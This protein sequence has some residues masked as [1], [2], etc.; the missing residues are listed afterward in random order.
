[1][2]DCERKLS[3]DLATLTAEVKA[4][5]ELANERDRLYSERDSGN[6]ERVAMAFATA[7]KLALKTE[8]ALA[9]YKAG[10]NE[11]RDTVKDLIASL[12]EALSSRAA[13]GIGMEKLWGWIA[14][15]FIAVITVVGL[16]LQR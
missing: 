8:E 5:R 12:R 16:Y 3:N 11:W 9:E 6:K 4:L 13:T 2:N 10:A 1:M 7:E 14:A 15:A